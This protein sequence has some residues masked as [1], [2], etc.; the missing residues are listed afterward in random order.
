MPRWYR[1]ATPSTMAAGIIPC[2]GTSMGTPM[3]VPRVTMTASSERLSWPATRL[4]IKR[5]A[6]N[7]TT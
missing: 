2:S 1:T 5:T 7:R 6:T 3:A 4:P